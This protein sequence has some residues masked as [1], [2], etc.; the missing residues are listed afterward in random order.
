MVELFD[1]SE[2][3]ALRLIGEGRP[4]G[5][6]WFDLNQADGAAGRGLWLPLGIY[7]VGKIDVAP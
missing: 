6:A 1:R 7:G 4:S 3:G 5:C 2:P